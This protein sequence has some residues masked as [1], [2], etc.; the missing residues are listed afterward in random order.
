MLPPWLAHTI[1]LVV[2]VVWLVNFIAGLVSTTY[3]GDTQLNL[4]FMSIVGGAVALKSRERTG[5]D[6]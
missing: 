2:T 6:Q 1:I 4:V 3:V 5:G